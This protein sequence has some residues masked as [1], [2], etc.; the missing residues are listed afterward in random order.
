MKFRL[1]FLFLAAVFASQ[2]FSSYTNPPGKIQ[3]LLKNS[4][5]LN[6]HFTGFALYDPANKK[7]LAQQFSDKYFTPASNTKLYTFYTA[8]KLLKDSVPTLQYILKGDSLIFW[9]AA[10]PTFLH[11]DFQQTVITRLQNSGKKIY[12]SPGVYKG[13]FYGTG[14][15]YDDYNEYYQPEISELP[16]YGNIIRSSVMNGKLVNSPVFT[17]STFTLQTDSAINTGRFRLK[18]NILNNIFIEPAIEIGANYKQETPFKVSK[19]LI[20]KLLKQR[21]PNYGGMVDFPKPDQTK[22]MFNTPVDTVYKH[23]LLPSDNFIAE[24]LL[25]N[26]SVQNNLV[27]STDSVISYMKKNYLSDLPDEIQWVDGSGLS[28]QDLFSPRDMVALCEKIYEAAGSEERLFELL[29]KGGKT[30]T[31]KNY[32]NSEPEPFVFAK[33]GSLSNN[34][35]L[36]GFI[37]TRKGKTLIFSF[38]NNNYVRPTSDIRKEMD[39][40]LTLV[41]EKY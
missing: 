7:M 29:P 40:I 17:D 10:D 36:T 32:F 39:R 5:I 37:K 28:R 4:A 27:M 1:Y 24:H 33:T 21:L 2:I 15:S 23:M 16:L 19:E 11:P 34:H 26:C 18:R 35:N 25:L 41:H 22:L 30:G 14:W 20:S 6:D 9:A 31:L 8:L 13:D 12:W 38:M 3:R